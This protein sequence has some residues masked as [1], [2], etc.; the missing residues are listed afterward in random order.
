MPQHEGHN[1]QKC[2]R[3]C[4]FL[5][6]CKCFSGGSIISIM[7]VIFNVCMFI[8]LIIKYSVQASLTNQIENQDLSLE[9]QDYR[10]YLNEADRLIVFDMLL[11]MALIFV[12]INVVF[13]WLPTIFGDLT[14]LFKSYFNTQAFLLLAISILMML[15]LAFLRMNQ[16]GWYLYGMSHVLHSLVRN[17]MFFCGGFFLES[18]LSSFGIEE[19][20]SEL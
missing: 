13:S 3:Y 6:K 16:V 8:N 4:T 2:K 17:L 5:V 18:N 7:T 20:L 10:S 14:Q 9:Y 19:N 15:L 12:L 11:Y 1:Y